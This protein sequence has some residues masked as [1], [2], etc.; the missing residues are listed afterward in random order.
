MSVTTLYHTA[1]VGSVARYLS[2]NEEVRYVTRRHL[3]VLDAAT[4]LWITTLVLYLSSAVASHAEPG[5][6][7]TAVGFAAFVAASVFLLW[8]GLQWATTRYVFTTERVLLIEGVLSRKVNGIPMRLVIDT[9]YKQ[10]LAGCL[11]GYGHL[12][13]NL[14]G[15]PGLRTLRWLPDLDRAYK[16]ILVLAR[17]HD[18]DET[19][20][21]GG[22]DPGW[23]PPSPAACGSPSPA[24]KPPAFPLRGRPT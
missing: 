14:S 18:L 13:L 20:E 22:D 8:R 3:K 16:I 15:K 5:L 4:T 21:P 1:R 2:P 10:S 6:Q 23:G 11:L 19:D 9:V 17:G 24:G 7:L 12:E